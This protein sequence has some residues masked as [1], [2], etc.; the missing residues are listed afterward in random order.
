MHP[1]QSK[2]LLRMTPRTVFNQGAWVTKLPGYAYVLPLGST[3]LKS[4]LDH[5]Y[6]LTLLNNVSPTT[7]A[8]ESCS[9]MENNSCF[10]NRGLK[11][12]LKPFLS[13]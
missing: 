3:L 6:S 12:T 7:L 9:D 1:S 8:F 10:Y 2:R 5:L 4:H 11:I 13:V